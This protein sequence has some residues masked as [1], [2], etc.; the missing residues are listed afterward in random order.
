MTLM[1]TFLLSLFLFLSLFSFSQ[2]NNK[3]NEEQK[4]IRDLEIGI[5]EAINNHRINFSQSNKVF[6]FIKAYTFYLSMNII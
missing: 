5:I 3:L 1:K 6:L 2:K 4:F